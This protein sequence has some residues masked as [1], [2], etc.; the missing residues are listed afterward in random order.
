MRPLFLILLMLVLATACTPKKTDNPGPVYH[1]FPGIIATN[2]IGQILGNVGHEDGDWSKDSLWTQDEENILSY[3]DTVTLDG[4]WIPPMNKPGDRGIGNIILGFPNPLS[5]QAILYYY[6]GGVVKLKFA[7]VDHYYN[8]L[9]TWCHKVTGTTEVNLDLSDST[10]FKN[11][12]IY[13]LYYSMSASGHLEFWKGHG[14]LLICRGLSTADC[15]SH[16]P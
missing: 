15:Y 10:K 5:S 6:T 3:P 14:D 9:F 2:E 12:E 7:V 1:D 16:V 8:R 4:T 11:G 13:R